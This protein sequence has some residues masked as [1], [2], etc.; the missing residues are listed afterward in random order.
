MRLEPADDDWRSMRIAPWTPPDFTRQTNPGSL[1]LLTRAAGDF[2]RKIDRPGAAWTVVAGL[3]HTGEAVTILP[4]AAPSVAP[5]DVATHAPSLE[6]DLTFPDPGEYVLQIH[7]LPT[8]PLEPGRGLRFACAWDDDP[9]QEIVVNVP[10]G[11]P[12]W[13]QGVLNHRLTATVP[14]R[15]PSA[16]SHCLKL[17]MVDAGVVLDSVNVLPTPPVR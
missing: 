16:G 9:P 4:F 7:L 2:D 8:H 13:A 14:L 6:Y 17:F 12:A 15:A 10:D 11:S 3:G 5:A 1:P